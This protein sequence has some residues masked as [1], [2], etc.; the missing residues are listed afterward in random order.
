MAGFWQWQRFRGI[1]KV[2]RPRPPW[3]GNHES[4]D[5]KLLDPLVAP[6]RELGIRFR[7]DRS[8][9]AQPLVELQGRFFRGSPERTTNTVAVEHPGFKKAV[10]RGFKLDANQMVRVDFSPILASTQLHSVSRITAWGPILFEVNA[11][12]LQG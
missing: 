6:L 2:L 7:N 11:S 8:A 4:K 9:A 5:S 3:K 1:F 12:V 10:Q